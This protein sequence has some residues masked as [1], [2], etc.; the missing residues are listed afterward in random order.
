MITIASYMAATLHF[1]VASFRLHSHL[2]R[3]AC[4]QRSEEFR[5]KTQTLFRFT[6]RAALCMSIDLLLIFLYSA[7]ESLSTPRHLSSTLLLLEVLA[8]CTL[9]ETLGCFLSSQ[10]LPALPSA[11]F[12]LLILLRCCLRKG[13]KQTKGIASPEFHTAAQPA[14]SNVVAAEE[15]TKEGPAITKPAPKKQPGSKH[16]RC[17]YDDFILRRSSVTSSSLVFE[18]QVPLWRWWRSP[19]SFVLKPVKVKAPSR[20]TTT[21]VYAQ[22]EAAAP[23]ITLAEHKQGR[24]PSFDEHQSQFPP[25]ARWVA[26]IEHYHH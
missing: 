23:P 19:S 17:M 10:K 20:K 4:F 26:V 1:V 24:R 13:T 15:E 18:A 8:F 14:K 21:L 9:A 12:L 6:R 2:K 7:S 16:R 11:L 22:N 3:S 25:G 5:L